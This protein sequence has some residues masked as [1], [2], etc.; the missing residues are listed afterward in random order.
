MTEGTSRVL[1]VDSSVIQSAGS[2][3]TSCRKAL[4]DILAICHH[5]VLT[6]KILEEWNR[7]FTNYSLNWYFD[8]TSRGKTDP[9]NETELGEL[10]Q[11]LSTIP[12]D[13]D[14]RN[15]LKKDLLLIEAAC[16]ADGI[17]VTCDDRFKNHFNNHR[18]SLG[19]NKEIIWINPVRQ[20]MNSIT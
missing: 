11:K 6:E 9:K 18:E 20:E 12:I 14:I 5:V 13:E 1:V 15:I 3:P 8:M 4:E 17:I 2:S 10:Q 19:F 16:S 7:H